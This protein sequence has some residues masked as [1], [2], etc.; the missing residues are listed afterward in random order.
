MY[1]NVFKLAGIAFFIYILLPTFLG[2]V[3]SI[4]SYRRGNKHSGK[5]AL[6][7][8]DGPD[9][10][11]TAQVLDILQQYNAKASFFVVGNHAKKHPEL[12]QRILAEGHSLGTHGY[13]HSFAW[14]QGPIASIREIMLG[15]KSIALIDGKLPLYFR[16]SWG[17][18][19]LATY[20]YT[21]LSQQKTVLWTFMT[22]DWDAKS[23]AESIHDIVTRKTRSGSIIVFH[24]RCTGFG[25]AA[26]GPV[27]MV[28]ALPIILKELKCKG[29]EPVNLEQL[30]LYD[31]V[32]FIKK[33]LRR[34]WQVWELCFD[35]IAGLK[36]VGNEGLFRLAVRSYR[37]QTLKLPDGTLLS[38]GDKVI[39]LHLNNDFLQQLTT[40]ARSL[41]ATAI[42]LLRE[43]R[44]SLP[45]LA[46][47]ISQDPA[48]NGTKALIGITMIHRG[49]P[50]LGFTVYDL[51][52]RI[53]SLVAWYQRWLLFL[54]HPG[55]LSHIRRQWSKLVP[56]KVIITRNEL[57]NRYLLR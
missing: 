27:K 6:T 19:N 22:W 42:A 53:R 34:L 1:L 54:M 49:T 56:K 10:L 18:F 14:L 35:R 30:M 41:E 23:S 15:H 45:L 17:V 33:N 7:F 2:R 5:V 11:F 3:L 39:E 25:A 52:P 43:T 44:R 31:D 50:Q 51:S 26:E 40:K 38:P 24:D 46:K 13:H 21:L 9:P 36:P 57:L 4:G 16:P 28:Q 37:G 8:D 32:G 47:F 29:L 55:G 48:C 12:I 20:L